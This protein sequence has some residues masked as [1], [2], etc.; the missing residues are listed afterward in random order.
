MTIGKRLF[1]LLAVPLV[2]LLVSGILARI[3]LSR[4]EER[5]RFVAD[6]QF[7]VVAAVGTIYGSFAEIR[8]NA[9]DFLLAT[10]QSQRAA[11][12]AAFDANE[13]ALA[14]LLEQYG[15]SL[16]TDARNRRLLGD[17]GDLSRR[18]LVE[19][20][21]AMALVEE[22]RRDEALTYFRS[23][24]A[25]TGARLGDVSSEW[26]QY[27]RDVGSSA[28]RAALDAI[29]DTRSRTL[30]FNWAALLLTGL[31]GVLTF[32][33]IVTPIQALERSVKTV[34]AGDYTR[35]VPF[36]ESTDET[37][38]LARSIDV[39]KRGAAAIDDQRW[40]KSSASN[41]VGELQG[42]NSLAE[43]GQRLL[44]GLVPLLRGGVAGFY[45]FEEEA[46]RLR[47]TAAY[48]LAADAA[49]TFGL[50]EGLVGQCA[51]DR[52]PVT[53]TNLP[54]DYLL[55]ASGLGAAAP[56][57]VF[58][59]PLLSKNALLGVVETATFH[60]FD[61]REQALLAELMPLV[62]LSLEVLQRNLRTQ[63]LLGQ[64][65]ASEEHTR[66]IVESTVEGI[67]G[68]EP[69]GHITFANA[70][71]CR[72]LGFTPEEMIGQQAHALIHHHRPDGSVYPVEECP[73]RAACRSGHI[74]RVDDELLWRKDGVGFPVEYGTTPILKDGAI[75][76]AV[77]SFT[78]IT[79]RKE[80]ETRLRDTERFFRSV[81]ELAPDGLMVVDAKG[82]IRLANARCE[83]LFGYTR[84]EL[85]G[86]SVEVLVPVNVRA[87]H[88]ALRET[89]H[90][91]PVAREMGAN[92]EL[93]GLRRD[94]S[95]FPVEIG[96]SPL[97][98]GGSEGT[99]V[100]VSIRDVTERREQE[101][102]LK[103]AKARAED[104]TATK[105]MFLANM[106]HE[107]RTP[108]NAILNMTGLALEADLPP[109]PHQFISVA[110]SSARN[111]LGILN[112]I[113]DFSKIEADKLQLEDAPFSLRD[114]LEEVT[115][116][117][118]SVVIQKHVE[119]ITY[120]LPTVPDRLRGDALRV[121][122]VLTN[123]VSN[124]FKFTEQ[125]EVLLKV[126]T[127]PAGESEARRSEVLL[128]ISVRDTGIGISAEQQ[129]RL[130]QSFTQADSSTTRK[131][132]GTG[133]GLAISRRLARL[134]GGDLTVESGEGTGTT[135]FFTARLAVDARPDTPTRVA[136]AG[137]AERPVLIVEDTETSRELLE[138][139]LRSWSIPPVAVATAEEGLALLQHRN[140]KG[141]RDQFGLVILDWMLP[142]MNGL[143]AAERI[144][145]R[146]ETRTLPIVLISAYAGKE[147]EARSAALG[148]DVFLPKPITASSLFDAV[149]EAQG[150]RVHAARRALDAPLEREFDARVLL[151]EDN[152]ANQMVASELLSRL[153]I[154]LDIA[155]NGRQA[156][157]MVRAAPERYAAVLMDVQMPEMD[158]LAA[159]RALRGDSTLHALPIIAMTAN[160]MS[161]DLDACV[162]AGMND[163]ITKPIERKALLQ[164]LRR[165]LPAPPK[166]QRS[167]SSALASSS[168]SSPGLRAA[169]AND[170]PSLEGIDVAGSL[171]R[172]GLDFGS[173][174]RMLVRFA[175]GQGATL[176]ALRAAV[177][178]GDCAAVARHAHAIAGA[179]GNLGA[180]DLRAAAK[181]LER[182]GREGG[183]DLAQMLIAL[184]A[185]ASVV[186]RSIDTLRRTSAR[187]TTEPEQRL[188]PA[189]SRAVLERL[190]AALGDFDLSAASSALAD[191]DRVA[192]HGTPDDLARLRN[193]IDSY[194]YDEASVLVTRMLE[195]IGSQV[196]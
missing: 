92:R 148:V 123:L 88:A 143:D 175:D 132:G 82:V 156:L 135:F 40:V 34:A 62:A 42:A 68:M 54:P 194:E 13:R 139:L 85:V 145:A 111:L 114:V 28:A 23:V 168:P 44:S 95:E 192:A 69:D 116:T 146:D 127:L 76:G 55:I 151:A 113:L 99:H 78:D 169:A 58:A 134:M 91:A 5:S 75:L 59:S 141:A 150:A 19:A 133:L 154:E 7:A 124:A 155:S 52:K 142:G 137:V 164:T 16:V 8:V 97:P 170:A 31:L 167:D 79:K 83:A 191:L 163:H 89:F 12:R 136:P 130:F 67:Y 188:L 144:R 117:F 157:E 160:A 41:L 174:E 48:G 105:S 73:M 60:P 112:D 64:L 147:E 193:H 109:K 1:V 161:A 51:Q 128:R 100:A 18:Y 152:E 39:L 36:T 173:F 101:K 33:R 50:G 187:V 158:G 10:D 30:F 84:E 195:Q 185:R 176:D 189:E 110:H 35:V 140:R 32:R 70:A 98:A 106:S 53:L 38:G 121:R 74:R 90:R 115:E 107:I 177:A 165:W 190:R 153:G 126:E 122:Q 178:A 2:A 104:A 149:V 17:F 57:Q 119:L 138:T 29:D 37:G 21:S 196:P 181:A 43:F 25:P 9:R 14:R 11:A 166:R 49:A 27:N 94:G 102:A 56:A 65:Q 182:A 26:I 61:A 103:L 183:Q 20:K 3:Q 22:G 118:R 179:S 86:Q 87:G 108:M 184:E 159:T 129:E 6:S 131:Y 66:L 96:L 46:N 80:A 45:V 72:M 186:F 81:L 125:G 180:D 77:V 120:A 93:R 4:S 15:D 171:Q 172:L 63:E 24:I 162:A 71:A 47:R